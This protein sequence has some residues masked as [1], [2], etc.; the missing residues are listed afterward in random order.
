M[1]FL[2]CFIFSTR[3]YFIK[4]IKLFPFLKRKIKKEK[5]KLVARK[6]YLNSVS[7]A[8]S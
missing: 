3:F 6:M 5:K 4:K 1:V 7:G 2:H 8:R